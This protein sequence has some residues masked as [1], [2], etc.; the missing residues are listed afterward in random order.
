MRPGTALPDRA[1]PRDEPAENP[2]APYGDERNPV[3][4]CRDRQPF[5]GTDSAS[6]ADS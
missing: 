2:A 3:G 5:P 6:Q 4:T 1:L